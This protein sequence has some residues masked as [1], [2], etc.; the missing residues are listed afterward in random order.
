MHGVVTT[1]TLHTHASHG[2]RTSTCAFTSHQFGRLVLCQFVNRVPRGGVERGDQVGRWWRGVTVVRP[3]YSVAGQKLSQTMVE[4]LETCFRPLRPLR[5]VCVASLCWSIH[6]GVVLLLCCCC[7]VDIVVASLRRRTL[8]GVPWMC[9]QS[10]LRTGTA[11]GCVL[12][13]RIINCNTRTNADNFFLSEFE[14]E[15]LTSMTC[16]LSRGIVARE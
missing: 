16:S 9:V 12:Q 4:R 11:A 2:I 5:L 10:I 1:S 13:P 8:G 15:G 3:Y 6:E 7:C 14:A